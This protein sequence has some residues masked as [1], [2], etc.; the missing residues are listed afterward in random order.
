MT[1]S[2]RSTILVTDWQVCSWRSVQN[3][4]VSLTL[5]CKSSECNFLIRLSKSG[6]RLMEYIRSCRMR[7]Q[8][9]VHFVHQF[10]VL[11]YI[12]EHILRALWIPQVSGKATKHVWEIVVFRA[13]A[14][15]PSMLIF[16]RYD[17]SGHLCDKHSQNKYFNR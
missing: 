2:P 1:F 5:L 14:M 3:I 6:A 13:S 11:N 12:L 4:H 16:P 7:C 10:F 17:M 9:N 8:I 15:G